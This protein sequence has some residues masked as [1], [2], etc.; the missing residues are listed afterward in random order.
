V[1]DLFEEAAAAG[2][3][4]AMYNL[5]RLHEHG[6]AAAPADT[7]AALRWHERAAEA[8]HVWATANAARLV[9]AT[10]DAARACALYRAAAERGDADSQWELAERLR[11]G[12]T[13]PVDAAGAARWRHA[14]AQSGHPAA[15]QALPRGYKYDAPTAAAGHVR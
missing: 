14:A 4:D 7:A 10:G 2:D 3:T 9:E 5:A 8:G 12:R 13:C 11:R 6:D 15:L 1:R